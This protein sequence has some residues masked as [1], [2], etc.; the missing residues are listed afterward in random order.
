MSRVQ[1]SQRSSAA[2][3]AAGVC[4]A[5]SRGHA[6]GWTAGLWRLALLLGLSGCVVNPIPVPGHEQGK[7]VA[8]SGNEDDQSGRPN[9]A[10]GGGGAASDAG[11]PADA[12]FAADASTGAASD[13]TSTDHGDPDDA[14]GLPGDASAGAAEVEGD[15]SGDGGG[16]PDPA[17]DGV[18]P[19]GPDDASDAKSQD[20]AYVG[21]LAP[22][23]SSEV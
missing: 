5:S 8:T 1:T 10:T 16:D 20:G 12:G 4:R 9:G 17:T 19:G 6:D 21:N 18:T 11:G 13:S 23:R 22:N 7:G 15:A 3:P 2:A 14:V